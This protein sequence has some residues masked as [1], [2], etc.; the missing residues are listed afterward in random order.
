MWVLL[1]PFLKLAAS[2]AVTAAVPAVVGVVS[3]YDWS[4]VGVP[5]AVA[6]LIAPV[7]HMLPNPFKSA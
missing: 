1:L 4:Q 5:S 6:G 3:G 2:A 7:L